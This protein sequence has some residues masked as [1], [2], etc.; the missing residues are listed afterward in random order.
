M[1]TTTKRMLE[2]SLAVLQSLC[3]GQGFDIEWAYG[4]PRL[5]RADG[6]VDVSPRGTKAQ[7]D[8]YIRL[9]ILGVKEGHKAMAELKN[10]ERAGMS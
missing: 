6:S 5:M 10:N 4:Q 8:Q 2:R 3:P 9:V 1:Y 7:V